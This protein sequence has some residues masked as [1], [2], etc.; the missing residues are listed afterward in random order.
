MQLCT[1]IILWEMNVTLFSIFKCEPSFKQVLISTNCWKSN[2]PAI[3]L[4]VTYFKL[5]FCNF[6]YLIQYPVK[7]NELFLYNGHK[8]NKGRNKARNKREQCRKEEEFS[9][10]RLNIFM[11]FLTPPMM[12]SGYKRFNESWLVRLDKLQSCH[13]NDCFFNTKVLFTM[14]CVVILIMPPKYRLA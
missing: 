14:I 6:V 7:K 9:S 5:R 3:S 1:Y 13:S 2:K 10:I 11:L 4:H 8:K 12:I